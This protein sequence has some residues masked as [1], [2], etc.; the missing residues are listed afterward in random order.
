M[1]GKRAKTAGLGW[2]GWETTSS[3]ITLWLI[4]RTEWTGRGGGSI[5][6]VRVKRVGAQLTAAL[7]G[8]C[9]P[10]LRRCFQSLPAKP[11]PPPPPPPPQ[12]LRTFTAL[13]PADGA[14]RG[15]ARGRSVSTPRHCLSSAAPPQ[16]ARAA[17][18]RLLPAALW[19]VSPSLA[20]LPTFPQPG[21][22][23]PTP[24]LPALPLSLKVLVQQPTLPHAPT[25]FQTAVG[26]RMVV[27]AAVAA[28]QRRR[29]KPAG[30]HMHMQMHMHARFSA[31][32]T[33]HARRCRCTL[34]VCRT[35]AASES[36]S[37]SQHRA[38]IADSGYSTIG[39]KQ[40]GRGNLAF[41]LSFFPY[42]SPG[43]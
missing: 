23:P 2:V 24:P 21:P 8:P 5:S 18:L 17:A 35:D 3:P 16:S 34:T 43:P 7:I 39:L 30:E 25:P 1:K 4:G 42:S 11:P 10:R 36:V 32:A 20:P 28:R 27:A 40:R 15:S 22:P 12:P 29:M 19:R 33:K 9:T 6:R 38:R 26:A 14:R 41:S 13:P 31:Q 37:T